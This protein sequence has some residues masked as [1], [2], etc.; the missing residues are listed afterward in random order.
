MSSEEFKTAVLS[1][2]R[3]EG[4]PAHASTPSLRLVTPI[5]HPPQPPQQLELFASLFEPPKIVSVGFD[6]ITFTLFESIIRT[7]GIK[8]V[9]DIRLSP[10]FWGRGFSIESFRALLEHSKTSYEH[11][12][13]F[14]NKY[15]GDSWDYDVTMRKY[16]DYI[17]TQRDALLELEDKVREGPLLLLGRTPSHG[18]SARAILVN[19]L[20]EL[21]LTFSLRV[22]D[23]IDDPTKHMHSRA[24][25]SQTKT[26][27]T[28]AIPSNGSST[29][30][31]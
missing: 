26:L 19:A 18:A 2:L 21:G 23:K 22:I 13:V 4:K 28:H 15:I 10:S 3:G 16:A 11:V 6:G 31:M 29:E 25:E 8:K 9:I 1:V 7:E 5:H 27:S 17:Q 24:L 12:P 14:A 20:I 30:P